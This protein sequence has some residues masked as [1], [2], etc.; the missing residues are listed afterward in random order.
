MIWSQNGEI[1]D[2][3]IREA[4][5]SVPSGKNQ[6]DILGWSL[7]KGIDLPNIIEEVS[8]HYLQRGL[9]EC[10]GNK[11][12]AAKKLGFKSYQTLNNWLEKYG[13]E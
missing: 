7:N 9:E 6:N 11:S 5:L 2:S 1:R 4:M 10:N 13:L 8:I 12:K 3:N